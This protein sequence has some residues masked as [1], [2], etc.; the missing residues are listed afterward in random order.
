MFT[1]EPFSITAYIVLGLQTLN[2]YINIITDFFIVSCVLLLILAI[3]KRRFAEL[4]ATLLTSFGILGIFLGFAIGL[5]GF[6]GQNLDKSL[7]YLMSGLKMALITGAVGIF[8][9]F[10]VKLMNRKQAQQP[11]FPSHQITPADIYRALKEISDHN[12]DQKAILSNMM[13]QANVYQKNVYKIIKLQ[14]K[15]LTQDA[16]LLK[17]LNLNKEQTENVKQLNQ[18]VGKLVTWQENYRGQ[19]TQMSEQFTYSLNGIEKSRDA[20][21]EIGTV[22]QSIPQTVQQLA[23]VMQGLHQ[24]VEEHELQLESFQHLRQQAGDAFPVIEKNLHD[25]TRGMQQEVQQHLELLETTLETQMDMAEA[26]LETQMGGFEALQNK[27]AELLDAKVPSGSENLETPLSETQNLEIVPISENLEIPET[28]NLEAVP[29]TID[30]YETPISEVSPQKIIDVVDSVVDN[31]D[32]PSDY[33]ILQNQ[34]YSLMESEHYE[35]AIVHFG[36]AIEI[37]LTEFSLFYNQACCY[38][39][40]GEINL[41][42]TTLQEAIAL[43]A[44]CFEMAKTDSDFDRIRYSADF[45]SL[46]KMAHT[47]S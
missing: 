12:A 32:S 11:A 38:A 23:Q 15:G 29:E 17:E 3:Y 40:L 1:T 34:A 22:M 18:A 21:Q 44:E 30:E 33:E 14:Q 24:Q 6:D 5:S 20:L 41:A 25:L 36:Q 37:N 13:E 2:P 4:S 45:Q 35:E 47:Q 7:P 16:P 31:P 42:I 43:N 28:Q 19:M 39:S 8:F 27:F 46:L 10:L 26:S 9:A